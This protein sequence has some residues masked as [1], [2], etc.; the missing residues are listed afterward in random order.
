MS[1]FRTKIYKV[2]KTAI[3]L[4][5]T[6]LTGERLA[7]SILADA[8]YERLLSFHRRKSGIV[9]P[10]LTEHVVDLFEL[11]T[12]KADFKADVVFCCIGTTQS[13]TSDK[14]QYKAIDYG[15]PVAAAKLCKQNAIH[16]II[17]ISAWG[18]ILRYF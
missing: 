12:C 4:G 9:H 13:K 7:K 2:G 1:Y 8:G 17:I 10:K 3:I 6:G 14:S 5:I 15:I 16:K 11:E 18:L